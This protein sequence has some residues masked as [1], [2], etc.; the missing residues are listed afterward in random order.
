MTTVITKSLTNQMGFY[1]SYFPVLNKKE[2]EEHEIYI[3]ATLT[4]I[5]TISTSYKRQSFTTY[6]SFIEIFIFFF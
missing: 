3:N 4:Y 2:G 6:L 5:L 1:K